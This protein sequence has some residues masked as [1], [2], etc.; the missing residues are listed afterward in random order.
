MAYVCKT[1]EKWRGVNALADCT[2]AQKVKNNHIE[3]QKRGEIW[4]TVNMRWENISTQLDVNLS[5]NK[6]AY[7]YIEI[8]L[9]H[10]F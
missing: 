1:W 2:Y 4:Y 9:E 5:V 6:T 3:V 8:I 7:I 10:L